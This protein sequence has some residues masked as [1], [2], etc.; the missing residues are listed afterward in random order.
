MH[1]LVTGMTGSG[2]TAFSTHMLRQWVTQRPIG[3]GLATVIDA[4]GGKWPLMN[5]KVEV[6]P[7]ADV[8]IARLKKSTHQLVIVDESEESLDRFE[9]SH[10]WLATQARHL[11]H[12]CMFLCQRPQ[13]IARTVRA[14]CEALWVFRI[15]E[16][17]AKELWKEFGDLH[18]KNYSWRLKRFHGLRSFRFEAPSYFTLDID[19]NQINWL[20]HSPAGSIETLADVVGE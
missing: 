13:Q 6:I 12:N 14:Q 8:A 7:D 1:H 15:T 16:I 17:D 3:D 10:N 5:G 2:K 4:S 9:R 18:V 19:A 11:G 20:G